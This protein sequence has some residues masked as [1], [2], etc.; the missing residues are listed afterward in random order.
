[1]EST[2]TRFR[3]DQERA[4]D[5]PESPAPAQELPDW[6]AAIKPSGNETE[7][8]EPPAAPAGPAPAATVTTTAVCQAPGGAAPAP[9]ARPPAGGPAVALSSPRRPAGAAAAMTTDPAPT[10][11]LLA[12]DDLPAWLRKL[13]DAPAPET[14]APPLPPAPAGTSALPTWLEAAPPPEREAKAGAA[15]DDA[16]PVWAPRE[17]RP[18]SEPTTG[19]AIFASL[20]EASVSGSPVQAEPAAANGSGRMVPWWWY[21]VA[22]AVLALAIVAALTMVMR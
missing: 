6:L 17:N 9:P 16:P 3:F 1:M 18:A 12:A 19:A 15:P 14:G 21:V 8:V 20:T 11:A 22:A 5:G 13:G 7:P 10:E 2:M 4:P